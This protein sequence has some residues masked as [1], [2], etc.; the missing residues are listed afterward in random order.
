M[1][2]S[3]I[4]GPSKNVV[5]FLCTLGGFFFLHSDIF[6]FFPSTVFL[7][8]T[9]TSSLLPPLATAFTST[10]PSS[11]SNFI[12]SLYLSMAPSFV[13]PPLFHHI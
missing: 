11:F 1:K 9:T 5:S 10:F 2:W 12:V 4:L 3:Y 13:S 7:F 8:L 6:L